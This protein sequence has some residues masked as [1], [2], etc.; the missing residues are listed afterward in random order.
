MS[1]IIQPVIQPVSIKNITT[2]PLSTPRIQ[3]FHGK[4][5]DS[6]QNGFWFYS[7]EKNP[8]G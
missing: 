3:Q 7:A 6:V 5:G 1:R 8:P 2:S 4:K